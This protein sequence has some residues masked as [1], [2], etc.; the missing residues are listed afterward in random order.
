MKVK[1]WALPVLV[2]SVLFTSCFNNLKN[3]KETSVSFYMD[4][5]TV[6]KILKTNFTLFR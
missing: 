3:P 2:L 1:L 5:A 6:S 4:E